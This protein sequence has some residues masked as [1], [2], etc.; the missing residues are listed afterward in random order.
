MM[1]PFKKIVYTGKSLLVANKF[2]LA[3]CK[4]LGI[5]QLYLENDGTLYNSPFSG[6]TKGIIEVSKISS[7]VKEARLLIEEDVNLNY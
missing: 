3:E 7:L 6:N 4:K 2:L 5:D 1:P